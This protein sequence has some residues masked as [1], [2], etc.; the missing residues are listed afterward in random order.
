M[1]VK[2]LSE[3][4]AKQVTE[5]LNGNDTFRQQASGKTVKLQNVVTGAEGE[6]RYY[7]RLQD[8]QAEVGLGEELVP[9]R[10]VLGI[11]RRRAGLRER[12]HERRLPI[13]LAEDAVGGRDR[14]HPAIPVELLQC[15]PDEC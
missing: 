10:L 5:A 2:Y 14:I 9:E 12:H 13:E 4:W 1:A 7:F 15:E 8:G 11:A 6:T 3:D